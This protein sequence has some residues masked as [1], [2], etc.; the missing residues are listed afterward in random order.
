MS[1]GVSVMMRNDGD[2]IFQVPLGDVDGKPILRR[3][4]VDGPRPLRA[5]PHSFGIRFSGLL[6]TKPA[7]LDSVV[8]QPAVERRVFALP[9]GERLYLLHNVTSE[10]GRT[11]QDF[12]ESWPPTNQL[13]VD[14]EGQPSKLGSSEDRRRRKEFVTLPPYGVALLWIQPGSNPTLE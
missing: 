9:S 14:G 10:E 13:V 5:G 1:F 6:M 2:K 7:L 3:A 12:F 11:D 8:V 4:F